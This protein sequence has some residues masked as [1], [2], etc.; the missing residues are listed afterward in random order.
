MSTIDSFT[1]TSSLTLGKDIYASIK[2]DNNSVNIIQYTQIGIIVTSIISLFI[3]LIFKNIIDIW[4]IF[5]TIGASSILVPFI[6][7]LYNQSINRPLLVL[8]IPL[9]VCIIAYILSFNIEPLYLGLSSSI[10]LCYLFKD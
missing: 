4:Y 1:F 10:V 9:L 5:G 7:L 8:T 6:I 3:I 2:S